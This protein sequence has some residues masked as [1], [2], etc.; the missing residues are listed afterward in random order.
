MAGFRRPEVPREQMVLWSQRLDDAIPADH[1]V[2]Q[3]DYL[4]RAEAF[5]GTFRAWEQQYVLLEGKPPYHPRDLAG[6]YLYGMLNRIRSSRQLE[7]ASYNRLDMMWLTSGQHPDH[8]TIAG[9]VKAHGGRLR[10][11]FRDVLRV[12]IRAG[13]VKLD[14][15]AIDG[16]KIEAD[17]G[18][19]S[20]HKEGTLRAELQKLD[21]Q[22]SAFQA[23]WEANERRESAL[24]GDEV[25]WKPDETGTV[26]QRLARLKRQQERLQKALGEIAR[27][28]EEH[29]VGP[30]PKAIAS[31][32]DPD[33]RVMPDKEGKSKPNYNGQ[34]AV[35]ATAGMVVAE[36]LNDQAED[37]GQLTPM[38][39]QTKEN[40]G[41]LPAEVSADSQYNTGPD[42][43]ALE[44]AQVAGYLPDHG[45]RSEAP[46][47]Q[48]PAAQ[49]LTAAQAGETLTDE[50][51]SALP[52]DGQDRITKAAFRYDAAADVY[53]CPMGHTLGFVR[54]SQ[55]SK[56]WGIAVRARYG[57]GSAC[58]GCPR[59]SM[60]CRDPAKGRT[61]SR[62]QYEEYRQ[63]LRA[64]MGTEEGRRR[65]RLRRHTVEPRFGF[66]KRGLGIRRFLRRGLASVQ[67]EWTLICTAVN[68]GIALRH[69][70]EV[71]K[72]L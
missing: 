30:V 60:C 7:Q 20:V 28:R 13:L 33:S 29:K 21:E 48:T 67:V 26:K 62:D 14:H 18:R 69:W 70:S 8:A 24:W 35:D 58:A 64:R 6:L 15:V 45:E 39:E 27:R 16:T 11:L 1:P 59:A 68:V 47:P 43:E 32:T 19:G 71:V 55:D 44:K 25:P 63:R 12:G 36:A 51:W 61:I 52:K 42:L 22:I 66:I 17:A 46:D 41:R 49:A 54:N 56:R 4:L 38:V 53:R 65:Y 31:V 72:V 50:Q 37:S 57:G 3:L 5:S 2:R 34:V 9:F 23:E 40:C 10:G